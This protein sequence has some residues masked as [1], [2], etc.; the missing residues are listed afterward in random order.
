MGLRD[1]SAS[2][3][4]FFRALPGRGALPK[5]FATFFPP[6]NCP[7]HLDIKVM[8]CVYLLVISNT[9]IIKSAKITITIVTAAQKRGEVI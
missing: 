7:S 8:L 2:K 6:S 9:K 1:A 5:L 4:I 3:N